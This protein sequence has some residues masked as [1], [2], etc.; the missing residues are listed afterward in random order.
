MSCAESLENTQ[1]KSSLVFFLLSAYSQTSGEK[2]G[3][4]VAEFSRIQTAEM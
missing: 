1:S 2:G 4:G 3:E